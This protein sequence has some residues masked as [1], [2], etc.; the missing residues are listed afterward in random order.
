MSVR[1]VHG[2]IKRAIRKRALETDRSYREMLRI[3][4]AM[5]ISDI[6]EHQGYFNVKAYVEGNKK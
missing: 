5:G 6:A 4:I 3:C 1:L 2:I